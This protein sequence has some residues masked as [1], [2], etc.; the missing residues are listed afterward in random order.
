MK[1]LILLIA[2]LITG[3]A[4]AQSTI[5]IGD[6]TYEVV[7][8]RFNHVFD[9]DEGRQVPFHIHSVINGEMI[10]NTT[11]GDVNDVWPRLRQGTHPD[12]RP[13]LRFYINGGIQGQ[14]DAEHPVFPVF[15][16]SSANHLN[17]QWEWRNEVIQFDGTSRFFT[18]YIGRRWQPQRN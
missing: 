1:N 13:Y 12:Q 2:I 3:L 11:I 17:F 9:T 4:S 18:A 10:L 14:H 5:I 7:D 15:D 6:N 8:R 16:I